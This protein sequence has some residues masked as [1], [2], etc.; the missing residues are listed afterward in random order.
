MMATR[1]LRGLSRSGGT[2]TARGDLHAGSVAV[3]TA[4][5]LCLAA[6]PAVAQS[7]LAV[8]PDGLISQSDV[9]SVVDVTDVRST[10]SRVTA[11]LVNRSASRITDVQIVVRHA[12]LWN[13][14]RRPGTD[15]PGRTEYYRVLGDI[16]PHGSLAF[17][18][19]P[20][21]P[22]PQRSD[23]TFRTSIEI[24]AFTEV[25]AE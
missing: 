14:E 24:A 17:E 6:A 2:R 10:D 25:G 21:P 12:F 4:T 19:Q 13:D 7:G 20:D 22:L 9:R 23:G 11:T 8:G 3:L 15:N 16:E 5:S 18:Y 1:W